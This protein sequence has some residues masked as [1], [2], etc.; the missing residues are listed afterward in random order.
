MFSSC[1]R[2]AQVASR[3]ALLRTQRAYESPKLDKI[4]AENQKAVLENPRLHSGVEAK[5]RQLPAI[6]GVVEDIVLEKEGRAGPHGRFWM[7]HYT[8]NGITA[9]KYVRHEW[10]RDTP[11]PGI[12]LGSRVSVRVSVDENDNKI[13]TALRPANPT[14]LKSI[15]SE[16]VT[17]IEYAR[18]KK[19]E[20][21]L[22]MRIAVSTFGSPMTINMD[23]QGLEKVIKTI[24]VFVKP[25]SEGIED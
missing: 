2:G 20:R 13:I 25:E 5:V 1:R 14:E 6:L 8:V 18:A 16:E 22:R 21:E 4:L 12:N 7:H 19:E 10:Q 11:E 23:L 17:R 24:Y 15:V 3:R 9:T